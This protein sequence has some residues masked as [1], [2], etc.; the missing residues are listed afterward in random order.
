MSAVADQSC[1]ELVKGCLISACAAGKVG[2]SSTEVC[3]V[4]GVGVPAR[5]VGVVGLGCL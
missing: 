5:D 2:C 3:A 4:E 1:G